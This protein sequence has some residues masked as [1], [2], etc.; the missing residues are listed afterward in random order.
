MY[1]VGERVWKVD[2]RWVSR[3]SITARLVVDQQHARPGN[4]VML[5]ASHNACQ[6]LLLTT[7]FCVP[8]LFQ[9]GCHCVWLAAVALLGRYCSRWQVV[10]ADEVDC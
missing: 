8:S 10:V 9:R 7:F 4:S 6:L 1:C 2:G 5:L 3:R